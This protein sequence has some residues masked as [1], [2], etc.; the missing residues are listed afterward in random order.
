MSKLTRTLAA[1][2]TLMLTGIGLSSLPARAGEYYAMNCDDLWYAR[3]AIYAD[4]GY[5][6]KT[7]QA[8]SVFGEGCFGRKGRL[9]RAETREV[10]A[11]RAAERAQYCPTL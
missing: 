4:A 3:N 6:F 5:C 10:G 8:I 2:A 7:D 1:A 9:T 11:I